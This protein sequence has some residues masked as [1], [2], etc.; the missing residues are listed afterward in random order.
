MYN[1]DR[2]ELNNR[3][4]AEFNKLEQT[5][6]IKRHKQKTDDGTALS[7]SDV[8]EVIFE[9]KQ[10]GFIIT[11]YLSGDR[12]IDSVKATRFAK[13]FNIDPLFMLLGEST[14]CHEANSQLQEE[15]IALRK[16]LRQIQETARV[17]ETI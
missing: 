1:K 8:A 10:Y 9:N 5:G 13:Y 17:G 3:F 2:Q 12:L 4:I 15:N 16:Q 11:S 6:R 14:P 7:M